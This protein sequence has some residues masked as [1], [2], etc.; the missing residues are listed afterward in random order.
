MTEAPFNNVNN[1]MAHVASNYS[2][3]DTVNKLDA[4]AKSMGLTVF[5]RIDF[6]ADAKTVGLE[7][8]PKQLLIFGNPKGG[9]PL[10][11]SAPSLAIDLPMNILVWEDDEAKVWLSNNDADYLGKRHQL[12]QEQVAGLS[13]L[14]GSLVSKSGVAS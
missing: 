3:A 7:L 11:I 2:V 6:A 13:N 8:K 9:T 4:T 10:M 12:A 5:A 14:T 1:G